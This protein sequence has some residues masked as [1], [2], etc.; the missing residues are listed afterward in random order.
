MA[1]TRGEEGRPGEASV[2]ARR[3]ADKSADGRQVAQAR[4]SGICEA[5][6]PSESVGSCTHPWLRGG[7]QSGNMY[8]RKLWQSIRRGAGQR[9]RDLS[10]ERRCAR[11]ARLTPPFRSEV[12]Q[13]RRGTVVPRP[14]ENCVRPCG[15]NE[16]SLESNLPY[17]H[18]TSGAQKR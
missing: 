12:L 3:R 1:C 15:K 14:H 7:G 10:V 5:G 11:L 4:A 8:V 16:I 6:G 13:Q 9:P 2:C 18:S 17:L